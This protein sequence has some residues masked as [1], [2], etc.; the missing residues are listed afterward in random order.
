MN[1]L[2]RT[3]RRVLNLSKPMPPFSKFS[4]ES[5]A[6]VA[7]NLAIAPAGTRS[8]ILRNISLR[9]PARCH[10]ALVGANGAG[11]STLLRTFAGLLPPLEGTVKIFGSPTRTGNPQVC[12]LAQRS[13]ID[14]N[15]PISVREMVLAGR[16]I[17]KGL[18]SQTT[19][20]EAEK[21]DEALQLLELLDLVYRNIGELSGGQQQRVLLARAIC[22][23]AKLLLLDEPYSALDTHSRNVMDEFL[24]GKNGRELTLVMATHNVSD[25]LGHFDCI[26]RIEDCELKTLRQ[27]SCGTAENMPLAPYFPA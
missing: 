3:Q 21:A 13:G 12:F 19:K 7:E 18:F 15:F 17:R 27:C 8:A 9:V 2:S 24:F 10:A 20:A 22:Q 25:A 5:P 26:L 4:L 1:K 16:Y 11:K 14:W 23:E 6:L